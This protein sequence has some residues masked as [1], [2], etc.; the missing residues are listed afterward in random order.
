VVGVQFQPSS[1]RGDFCNGFQ[2][3]LADR[4][5]KFQPSSLRGDFCNSG[6]TSVVA[7]LASFQPSSLRGDFCNPPAPPLATSPLSSFNPLLYE[8]TSA[9]ARRVTLPVGGPVSTLFS[10]RGLLQPQ[11]NEYLHCQGGVSTL[12]STRGLL[13]RFGR[14]TPSFGGGVFQPSSLRGDFCN[15]VVNVNVPGAGSVS[16]LFSTR[17]LLQ[18]LSPPW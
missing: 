14:I 7:P 8:G 11:A 16:T 6:R 13:Q 9:T 18:L 5:A 1:L 10:T 12:F 17:G 3:K 15:V 2:V 4:I